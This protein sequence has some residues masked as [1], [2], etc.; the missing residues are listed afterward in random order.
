MKDDISALMD[1]EMDTDASEHL[2]K[3]LK[4]DHKLAECWSTY[5]MIG[6]AIRGDL[7]LRQDFH[8]RLMQKLEAEPT[9]LAPRNHRKPHPP[10]F[11]MTAV[12]SVA[13][14]MFVGWMVLQQ[15]VK[16]PVNDL[17]TATVA[18]NSVS[19][20]SVNSYLVA[21]QSTFA[22]SGMQAA[23]YVRPAAM[24]ENGR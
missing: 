13:A 16:S 3:A 7:P 8:Q 14:V 19:P 10:S 17:A 22:G 9:V 20:E 2:F 18:Q 15:Q 6:D 23:Y 21:H 11:W 24:V 12:A 4:A 5:H 1:D